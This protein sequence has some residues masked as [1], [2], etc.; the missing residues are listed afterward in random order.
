MKKAAVLL[1]E[2]FEE[3]ESLFVIDIFRRA[4]I[5]CD[6][7]SLKD[8]LVRGSHDIYVKADRILDAETKNDYDMVIL[9]GGLPGATNLRDNDLV[10]DW[11]QS[12]AADPEKYVAAICAA[13]M[14]LARAG[15]SKGRRL[16]S[17]PADKYRTLFQDAEYVDDPDEIVV[18]DGHLITSRGPGTTLPFAYRLVEIM[19][20]DAESLKE[21]MLYNLAKK[22]RQ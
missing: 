13:P 8:E 14:V 9:P 16:T 17:Y 18:V 11:V 22:S 1:A 20:G 10:I 19:G 7:V 2:G 15:V 3:G 6:G 21:A 5:A 4:K 12:F